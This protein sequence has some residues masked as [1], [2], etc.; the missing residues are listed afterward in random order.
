MFTIRWVAPD[1]PMEEIFLGVPFVVGELRVVAP[2]ILF[3]ELALWLVEKMG[4]GSASRGA[5]ACR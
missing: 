4:L 5:M 2:L 1:V 3:P